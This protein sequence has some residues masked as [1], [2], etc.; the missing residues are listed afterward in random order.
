MRDPLRRPGKPWRVN[1][2]APELAP[3]RKVFREIELEPGFD[4]PATLVE[5]SHY[6][7]D[8]L[9]ASIIGPAL[10]ERGIT[11]GTIRNLRLGRHVPNHE[12]GEAIYILYVETTGRKP[13]LKIS[14][15]TRRSLV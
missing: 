15:K 6:F 14:E 3:L 4:F 10:G 12:L 7:S 5:L 2:T 13:P 1:S 9:L 8:S 11:T